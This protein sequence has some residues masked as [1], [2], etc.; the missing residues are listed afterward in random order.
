MGLAGGALIQLL[1]GRISKLSFKIRIRG[2]HRMLFK[3]SIKA[4][5]RSGRILFQK[6]MAQD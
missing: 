3:K 4:A 6:Q 2:F 5:F 1:F